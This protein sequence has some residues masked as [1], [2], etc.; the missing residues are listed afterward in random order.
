MPRLA[1]IIGALVV[2]VHIHG[3]WPLWVLEEP[4][5]VPLPSPHHLS[6]PPLTTPHGVKDSCTFVAGVRHCPRV[7]PK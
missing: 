5:R 7:E 4:R 6:A 1:P 3:W 2:S